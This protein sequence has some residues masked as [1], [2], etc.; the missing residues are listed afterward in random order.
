MIR[1]TLTAVIV[2]VV[3]VLFARALVRNWDALAD[4]DLRPDAWIAGSVLLFASAVVVSGILWGRMVAHLGEIRVGL[5][6]SVRVHCLSWLLKY[7]PGQ[8]GSV[9]NKLAWAGSR[10][11]SR[12]LTTLSFFYENAFLIIGSIIPPGLI[13]LMLGSVELGEGGV[14]VVT[15]ASVVPLLLLT[16]RPILRWGTNHVARRVFKREVPQAYFLGSAQA[17]KYQL[18]YLVP[19]VVNGAGAVLI[20]ISMFDVPVS[21]YIPLAC[22]YIFA[23]AA[24]L[25]AVFVPSGVGVRESVFVLLSVAYLPVEQAIVLALA[26]RL[27]A[28]LG[29]GVVAVIYGLLTFTSRKTGVS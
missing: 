14:V 25:L 3:G 19:R 1:V 8:V 20:A 17:L 16:S 11:V 22:A 28:T 7:I 21:D 13:L 9:A 12:S 15:A 23:G 26:A 18:Q 29:D 5:L 6:E 27:F 24:G 10:N 4:L 2:A